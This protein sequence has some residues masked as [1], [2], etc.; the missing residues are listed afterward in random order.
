MAKDMMAAATARSGPRTDSAARLRAIDWPGIDA[1]L[2]AEGWA[3]I[4][5]LLSADEWRSLAARHG[6]GKGEYKYFGYPF[7]AI[8]AELRGALYPHLAPIANRWN[9][10]MGIGT[11]YPADHGAFLD[12]CH[13]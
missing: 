12:R 5:G 13:K 10:A 2:S 7:P 6:F 3:T 1:S 9:E 8:V 4:E 11:R